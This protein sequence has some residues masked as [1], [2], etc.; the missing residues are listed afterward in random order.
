MN[1]RPLGGGWVHSVRRGRRQD[2][3]GHRQGRPSV[4]V[5]AAVGRTALDRRFADPAIG[6]PVRP[7]PSTK[8]ES[9]PAM[10]SSG[11]RIHPRSSSH[12]PGPSPIQ[13]GQDL[14]DQ[15][16]CLSRARW[17]SEPIISGSD[18]GLRLAL[19][20][21]MEQVPPGDF[22]HDGSKPRRCD[23]DRDFG[24]AIRSDATPSFDHGSLNHSAPTRK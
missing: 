9:P 5:H 18:G 14:R 8:E 21:P 7:D 12:A 20:A 11:T 16:S 15:V 3:S 23:S 6:T 2:R 24:G 1:S 17:S 19:E 13:H 22:R 4:I 10:A